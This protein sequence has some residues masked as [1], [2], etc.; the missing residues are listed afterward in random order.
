MVASQFDGDQLGHD[1]CHFR[2]ADSL[3]GRGFEDDANI[4]TGSPLGQCYAARNAEAILLVI[5]LALAEGSDSF[6]RAFLGSFPCRLPDA[7]S[8]A[9]TSIQSTP[10]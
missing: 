10:A 3:C 7:S 6:F 2:G 9:N 8:P 5:F 1:F 4:S